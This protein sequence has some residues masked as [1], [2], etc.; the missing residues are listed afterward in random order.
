MPDRQSTQPRKAVRRGPGPVR[1]D[2]RLDLLDE[3]AGPRRQNRRPVHL[4]AF[5][6]RCHHLSDPT[7]RSDVK[8]PA[9]IVLNGQSSKSEVQNRGGRKKRGM[10]GRECEGGKEKKR[11]E[12]AI[13]R[14]R[15]K[16]GASGEGVGTE[17]GWE[18]GRKDLVIDGEHESE[19]GDVATRGGSARQ[20]PEIDPGHTPLDMSDNTPNRSEIL[21]HQ[22]PRQKHWAHGPVEVEGE[23]ELSELVQVRRGLAARFHRQEP[24]DMAHLLVHLDPS[25]GGSGRA[26]C[27]VEAVGSLLEQRYPRACHDLAGARDAVAGRL[28]VESLPPHPQPP[29]RR[30]QHDVSNSRIVVIITTTT[31]VIITIS[32]QQQQQQ[33]CCGGGCCPNGSR[34]T[35]SSMGPSASNPIIQQTPHHLPLIPPPSSIQLPS[36]LPS[37]TD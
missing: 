29:A 4:G 32:V 13:E 31:I 25:R 3:L 33:H 9:A 37:P 28:D 34:C 23:G 24:P 36:T 20:R 16:E 30:R 8:A 6:R 17:W 19:K 15:Q 2:P 21:T 27:E 14:Q 1:V 26:D 7:H 18:W 11:R 12:R 10:E 35:I 5:W 22:T